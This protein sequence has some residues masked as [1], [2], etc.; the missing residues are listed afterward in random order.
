MNVVDAVLFQS[1]INTDCVAIIVPGGKIH[2]VTYG[3]IEHM[4]NNLT[5]VVAGLGFQPGDIV[6]ILVED[7]I[8]HV[9]LILALTRLGIINVSCRGR[10]LP[11]KLGAQALI[12]DTAGPF[13]NVA[14]IIPADLG[15]V[16]GDGRP[17]EDERVNRTNY[18]DIFRLTITSGSTGIPKA[19]AWTHRM[20]VERNARLDYTY[21]ARFPQSQRLY[22]DLG[23][24]AGPTFRYIFYSLMRGGTILLHG[25]DVAETELSRALYK[26]QNMVTSPYGLGEHIKFYKSQN[27]FRCD[28][29]HIV[30]VGGHLTREL[31]EQGREHMSR[32]I[33]SYYGATETGSIAAADARMITGVS[34]AA[35]YV[36]PGSTV[37]IVGT[38]GQ[39]LPAGGEGIVRLRT[40]NL[41]D[42]YFGDPEQTKSSFRDGYFYSGDLGYL[43]QEGLL[44]ITGREQTRLNVGG[45][46]VNPEVVETVLTSFKG[47]VDAAVFAAPNYLGIDEIHALIVSPSPI[48]ETALRAHCASKLQRIFIPV[49]FIGIDR[50]PR[51][52]TGKIERGGLH[53]FA[54]RRMN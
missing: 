6:G 30:V 19:I 7:K 16:A 43:N 21:G 17:L 45:D 8:F 47:V 26:V 4:V 48:D 14:R 53:D 36:L 50:I 32:N 25:G 51:N 9:G 3:Q 24:S 52:E 18:D 15:W 22:C 35:G 42:G 38:S 5:R 34:G 11:K 28:L 49:R 44:V 13:E 37:E 46:K 39:L 54:K 29:D 2:V 10:S 20:L 41:A 31:A 12:T 23:L 27:L 1:R 40:E 33:I